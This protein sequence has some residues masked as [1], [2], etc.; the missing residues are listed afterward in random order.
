M[1]M[2][3]KFCTLMVARKEFPCSLTN[4]LIIHAQVWNTSKA[5]SNQSG[6]WPLGVVCVG[7]KKIMDI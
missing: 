2:G 1:I 3:G 4:E 5:S 7:C 6:S